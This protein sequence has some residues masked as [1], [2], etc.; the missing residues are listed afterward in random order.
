MVYN[1]DNVN[2]N[3]TFQ[4]FG[5]RSSLDSD[6]MVFVEDIHENEFYATSMCKAYN[7]LLPIK[8]P[9]T[10]GDRE[11]NC[12]LAILKNY[13]IEKVYKG[14]EDEC[15]NS[16][17]YTYNNFEQPHVPQ[18][19]QLIDR[20]VELKVLRTLRVLLSFLSRSKY[21]PDVKKALKGDVY[22][23]I[24]TL[25][26][27]DLS[28]LFHDDLGKRNVSWED[29]LKTMSFQL[30]QTLPLMDDDVP[31]EFKEHYTKES[32]VIQYPQLEMLINRE[33]NADNDVLE[34]YKNFFI[35]QCLKWDFKE[36][37]EYNYK[38]I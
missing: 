4:I 33:E 31:K 34:Q 9:E 23:K 2:E 15:N 6:V 5:S 38:Q 13:K 18:V 26:N 1:K 3:V 29:Y 36:E 37:Y 27:I 25:K 14:T 7:E 21:R 22:L 12:N 20:D 19:L 24:Q 8:Y 10:F 35:H 32:I 16:L 28:K 17:Y 30:G 11:M